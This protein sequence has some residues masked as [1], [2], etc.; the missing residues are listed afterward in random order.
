MAGEFK[1]SDG[2]AGVDTEHGPL[3]ITVDTLR[4]F[5]LLQMIDYCA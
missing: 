4:V 3:A 2:P 1:M 5:A